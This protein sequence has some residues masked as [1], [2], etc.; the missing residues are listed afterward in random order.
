MGDTQNITQDKL[1]KDL[2]KLGAL[3]SLA[4][5]I[6]EKTR[7]ANLEAEERLKE[8]GQQIETLFMEID[9]R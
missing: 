8:I 3:A 1:E 2:S 5:D 4:V 7:Q 9:D 6:C